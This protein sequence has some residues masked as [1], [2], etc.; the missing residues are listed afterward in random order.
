MG[1]IHTQQSQGLH[2]ISRHNTMVPIASGHHIHSTSAKHENG[3]EGEGAVDKDSG[4]SSQKVLKLD[5]Q[6]L[7]SNYENMIPERVTMRNIK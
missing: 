7:H 1:G 2:R 6:R 5:F 4:E 3:L